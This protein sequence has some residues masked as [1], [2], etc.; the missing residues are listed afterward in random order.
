MRYKVAWLEVARNYIADANADW[1]L[2]QFRP[3]ATPEVI[4]YATLTHGNLQV[5]PTGVARRN[6]TRS[7][8][9]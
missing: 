8:F 3:V 9:R 5:R 1:L 2:Q 6:A 4:R 7:S